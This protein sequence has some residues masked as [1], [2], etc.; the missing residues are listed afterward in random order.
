MGEPL[1]EGV[2]AWIAKT[3]ARDPSARPDAIAAL[4]GLQALR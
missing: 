2:R 3:L 1:S 4:D